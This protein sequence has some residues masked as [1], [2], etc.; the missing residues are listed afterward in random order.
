M[1]IIKSVFSHAKN[2]VLLL[3]VMSLGILTGCAN[4]NTDDSMAAKKSDMIIVGTDAAYAPFSW[5]DEGNDL[6]GIDIE[7]WQSI[8]KHQNMQ[9]KIFARNFDQILDYLNTGKVDVVIAAVSYTSERAKIYDFSDSYFQA[10]S[11]VVASNFSYVKNVE[12]LKGLTVAVKDQTIGEYWANKYKDEY[13]LNIKHFATATEA[14]MAVHMGSC[15]FTIVDDPIAVYT[16]QSGLYPG[17]MIVNHELI[18]KEQNNN[19][20]VIVKKGQHPEILEKFNAGL[21][22][23]KESGEYDA[24]VKKFLDL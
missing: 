17:L 13:Q 21:K 10:G 15:D 3:S 24:I 20:Y 22:Q 9:Y 6:K 12:D 5:R 19:F 18:Q 16:L 23:I 14:F 2:A 11:V 8:A 1:E 7:I 4:T